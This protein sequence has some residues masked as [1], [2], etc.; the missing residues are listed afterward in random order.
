MQPNITTSSAAVTAT[1]MP[2]LFLIIIGISTCSA[3]ISNSIQFSNGASGSFSLN[4][5][6]KYQSILNDIIRRRSS[7]SSISS[8]VSRS[9][10]GDVNRKNRVNGGGN[11]MFLHL[12]A[13]IR[14][15]N[16]N[17]NR[18]EGNRNDNI[19]ENDNRNILCSLR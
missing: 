8:S 17:H 7:I 12:L 10:R 19:S 3:T 16:K 11:A 9:S 2:F 4:G 15:V 13:H 6:G 5:G 1:R 14:K 18:G